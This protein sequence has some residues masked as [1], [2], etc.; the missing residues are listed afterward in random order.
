MNEAHHKDRLLVARCALALF[1][2]GLVL[3][4]VM[5]L[6]VRPMYSSDETI[7]LYA[8]VSGIAEFLA[9][10][11]GFLGRRHLSGKVA[12]IGV[13]VILAWAFLFPAFSH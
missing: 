2:I 3:P 11:L 7:V 10:A 13:L 8:S 5:S 4:L 9:L 6:L 12:I 1:I